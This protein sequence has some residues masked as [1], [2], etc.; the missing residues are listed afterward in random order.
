MANFTGTS[1][2]DNLVGTSG[3]DKFDLSQGGE[4]TAQGG[5]GRDLFIMGGTLDA[6]DSIDGG[7]SSDV[8]RLNGDYSAGVVFNASTIVNIEQIQLDAGHAYNLTTDDG[9]V[10]AGATLIVA[11]GALTESLDFNGSDES[12][13]NFAIT[14]GAGNDTLWG[15]FGNDTFD[16]STGGNDEVF[17]GAGNDTVTVG[18]DQ[19]TVDQIDGGTG[20]DTVVV[21][22]NGTH[23][24]FLNAA[25][26]FRV[27][28]MKFTAGHDYDIVLAN[29]PIASTGFTVDGSALGAVDG[30]SFD[31]RASTN[32]DISFIGGAGN[33]TLLAEAN[34]TPAQFDLSHGGHD[35]AIGGLGADTFNMGGGL[36]FRDQ[37][38]GAGGNDVLILNGDY[39]GANAVVLRNSTVQE[40]PTIKFADGHSYDITL[41][42]GTT[43]NIFSALLDATA[44]SAGHS[45]SIDNTLGR[46]SVQVKWSAAD[47]TY[48]ASNHGDA[49]QGGTGGIYHIHGGDGG[50]SVTVSSFTAGDSIDGGGSTNFLTMLANNVTVTLDPDTIQNFVTMNFGNN[51][52]ITTTDSTVA[53]GAT[54]TVNMGSGTFDGSAETDGNFVIAV[55]GSANLLGG[56]LADEFRIAGN[57]TVTGGGGA[58]RISITVRDTGDT[59]DYNAVSDSTSSHYDI[60]SRFVGGGADVFHVSPIVTV[61]GVD[62]TVASGALSTATFDANLAA[63]VGAGQLAAD[64]AVLF[65]PNSGTLAGETFLIVD[66]NGTAGYQAGAD[67]VFDLK[68]FAGIITTASFN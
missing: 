20:N 15:G 62:A 59:L 39:T 40:F 35:I 64:H 5:G 17:G 8:L 24:E 32:S 28:A 3:N 25:N 61:T 60:V 29:S 48:F 46:A 26:L 1:G 51:E 54:L 12:D 31:A 66:A 23:K 50:D 10:A 30:L 22:G 53:A 9:N 67:L 4:D 37:L 42:R 16:I 68:L 34:A 44:V 7:A 47:L 2:N 13:G 52:D 19:L 21:T 38:D 43:L 6:G 33:D 45:V 14:A 57:T 63:A 27:E 58:D 11:G 56:A 18:Q 49:L 55:T 41:A 36:D 65:T